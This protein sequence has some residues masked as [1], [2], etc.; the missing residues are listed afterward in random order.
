VSLYYAGSP[1]VARLI[2]KHESLKVLGRS[3][4]YPVVILGQAMIRNPRDTELE[5][6]SLLLLFGW[7][8]IKRRRV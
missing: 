6:L 1:L 3:A 7:I 8:L 4:L 2:S 5:S